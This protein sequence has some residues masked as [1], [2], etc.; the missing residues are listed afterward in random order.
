MNFFRPNAHKYE[1]Q[2][3]ENELQK[4][5]SPHGIAEAF[6]PLQ[7]ADTHD[8][9]RPIPPR[10]YCSC[11]TFRWGNSWRDQRNFLQK[12]PLPPPQGCLRLTMYHDAGH[13]AK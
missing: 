13:P 2:V 11:R 3:F 9:P 1:V 6:V 8:R 10:F 12:Q 5:E 4:I 7:R